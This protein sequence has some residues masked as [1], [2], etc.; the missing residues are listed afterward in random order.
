MHHHHHHHQEE[1][2]Q[3]FAHFQYT[4]RTNLFDIMHTAVPCR[5]G[6][7][8]VLRFWE[9]HALAQNDGTVD[10]LAY[11]LK[12]GGSQFRSEHFSNAIGRRV[13]KVAFHFHANGAMQCHGYFANAVVGRVRR[14]TPLRRER[15]L[16]TPLRELHANGTKRRCGDLFDVRLTGPDVVG[17]IQC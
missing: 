2:R 16:Q 8:T 6:R 10:A 15:I 4:M 12:L 9:R 5:H 1:E 14:A 7:F 13:Q 3:V 17:V 11:A